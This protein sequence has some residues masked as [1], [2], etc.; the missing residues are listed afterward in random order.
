M[1][2]KRSP[3]VSEQ[4]FSTLVE[5][6]R[7][8]VFGDDG[9]LP[10][11]NELAD[12][13]GVSRASVRTALAK[14]EL[15]GLINRIHG[16]GTYVAK[17]DPKHNTLISAIWEFAGW[18][19]DSGRVP[20]IEPL[21]V[22]T[23][24]A[25][26]HETEVLDLK[27]GA[28]VVAVHRLFLADD[29]PVILSQNISPASIFLQEADTADAELP[30]H[31]FLEKFCREQIDYADAEICAVLAGDIAGAKLGIDPGAPIL[32]LKEIFY[33]QEGLPIAMGVNYYNDRD[34]S[35]HG[36][37]PWHPSGVG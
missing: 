34:L 23:R 11:E 24:P 6:I 17:K 9:R 8:G 2:I 21:K 13:F 5:R 22:I 1:A 31:G 4:V 29:Q 26:E 14:L 37:R 32:L 10:S 19:A 16:D 7:I 36:I 3:P 25:T 27:P 12:E 28:D 20:T 35:L 30:I 33:S 18:I 15:A